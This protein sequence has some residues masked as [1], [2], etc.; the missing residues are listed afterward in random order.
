MNPGDGRRHAGENGGEADHDR[1][2]DI[3]ISK[4]GRSVEAAVDSA[5]IDY[6]E[7]GVAVPPGD[8]PPTALAVTQLKFQIATPAMKGHAVVPRCDD[9]PLRLQHRPRSGWKGLL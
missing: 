8:R 9:E 7:L 5:G 4:P 2:S 6:R 1:I 3:R